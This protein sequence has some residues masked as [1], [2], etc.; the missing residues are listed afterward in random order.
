MSVPVQ[1]K[2]INFLKAL[3]NQ[4]GRATL[5]TVWIGI[6]YNTDLISLDSHNNEG[7]GLSKSEA[8]PQRDLTEVAGPI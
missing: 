7:N 5:I 6:A 8:S 2:A 3:R 4:G 1:R